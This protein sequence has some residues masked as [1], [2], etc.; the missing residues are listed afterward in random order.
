MNQP[1]GLQTDLMRCSRTTREW[2][3][4]QAAEIE[5]LHAEIK[6]VARQRN[7]DMGAPWRCVFC[8]SESHDGE[9]WHRIGCV[10]AGAGKGE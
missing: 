4:R 8:D 3:M 10:A 1:P 7:T 6:R 2:V 9:D 5:R